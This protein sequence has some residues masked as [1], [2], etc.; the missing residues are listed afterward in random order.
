MSR[1]SA[2]E[3]YARRGAAFWRRALA[4][5]EASD[6]SQA[7]FCRHEG[8]ALSTFQ[9]WRRKLAASGPV[10]LARSGSPDVPDGFAAVRVAAPG[11]ATQL[12]GGALELSFPSGVRLR[13]PPGWDGRSVA[14]VL[15]ALGVAGQC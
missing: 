3:R 14:E 11:E 13:I 6:V 12:A 2:Q 10:E 4:R 15:W 8:L 7:L 9:L 5:Y 1:R